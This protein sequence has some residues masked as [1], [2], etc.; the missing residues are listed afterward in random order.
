MHTVVQSSWQRGYRV[1]CVKGTPL[2]LT[3]SASPCA[4]QALSE[5]V[6]NT[7]RKPRELCAYIHHGS[8]HIA[9]LITP[10]GAAVGI[11]ST[12]ADEVLRVK[13]FSDP[14]SASFFA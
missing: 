2:I 9:V 3:C 7:H 13:W 4:P 11:V 1:I 10:C 5:P 12:R 14:V 6:Y 8:L